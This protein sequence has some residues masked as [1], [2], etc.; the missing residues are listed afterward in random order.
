MDRMDQ[1]DS[2][3]PKPIERKHLILLLSAPFLC[4]CY[5]ATLRTRYT[6]MPELKGHSLPLLNSPY[7]SNI[8]EPL[9]RILLWTPYFGSWYKGLNDARIGEVL[10]EN[11]TSKCM[12]TNE[13]CHLE[14]SDAVVFH[15]YDMKIKNLPPKRYDWQKWVFYFMESPPHTYFMDFNYT[16]YMFN[17]TMTYR[18]DSD[19]YIPY[20]RVIPRH[21][22][23]TNS[24]GRL[25]ALWKSK[26][27][28]AV[29]AVSNCF[30]DG[31]RE[32]FV[33]ELRKYV[34][35]DVYGKCGDHVCPKRR[36]D[37][38]Y[39][40]FET[41]YFY[42]LALENAICADYASEKLFDALGHYII[43]VVLGGANYSEIAPSHSYIDALS[44]ES[45][46]RLA[47][48][49]KNL[50]HNYTE[51]AAYFNWKDSQR[52]VKWDEGFCE[53][54]TKLHNRAE[55][56]RTSTYDDIGSWWFGSGG[57]CRSWSRAQRTVPPYTRPL[58]RWRWRLT[59]SRW[60]QWPNTSN[61]T[62]QSAHDTPM[63]A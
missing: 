61:A 23:S 56:Q 15:V 13:V 63:M 25:E 20:G 8:N 41:T 16:Y 2:A 43:P 40:E 24:K 37:A 19:I 14:D 47:E 11:C 3:V 9:P 54:C 7:N 50:S 30:T 32:D 58:R 12:V 28:T 33:A 39:V 52:V 17:W 4:F 46:K 49:L 51:Y 10:V 27:K 26:K 55:F 57:Q 36:R 34:D 45:P 48:Y 6:S 5:Y 62:N 35:V 31:R 44:F 21:P 29:W 18:R 1:K 53:L 42:V 60:L 38:C 59:Y 22:N